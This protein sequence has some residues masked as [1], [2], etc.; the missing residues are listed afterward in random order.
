MI[1][2][3]INIVDRIPEQK[4]SQLPDAKRVKIK[5]T[6]INRA[7]SRE[8][9][10]R[11]LP[12]VLSSAPSTEDESAEIELSSSFQ[13]ISF[14]EDQLDNFKTPINIET[15][16]KVKKKK[17][18]IDKKLEANVAEETIKAL[19]DLICNKSVEEFQSF[20]AESEIELQSI[21]ID[22]T[23]NTL[24]HVASV[25]KKIDFIEFL[26]QNGADPSVTNNKQEVA[27]IKTEDKEV[28]DVF[29]LFARKFPD[30]YNYK[31]VVV[32]VHSTNVLE[33]YLTFRH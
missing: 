30:K 24:L 32:K 15:K 10:Q 26:L 22:N 28:K 21:R 12:I 27:Y 29:V 14:T 2:A 8:D 33:I 7:K 11:P 6:N 23:G 16:T 5:N 31:K 3:S 20:L 18:K 13:E 9:V 4:H 19:D 25:K 1:I 17:T